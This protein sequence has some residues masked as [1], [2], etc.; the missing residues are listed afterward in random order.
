MIDYFS[1]DTI[2]MIGDPLLESILSTLAL[3]T[4]LRRM[5]RAMIASMG[6]V[7]FMNSA[8]SRMPKSA[9]Q[10]RNQIPILNLVCNFA[11]PN[12]CSTIS[13]LHKFVN[14][15]EYIQSPVCYTGSYS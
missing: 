13:K 8:I 10:F 2:V 5:L 15:V 1:T 9:T 11:I 12:L 14:C 4:S 6:V 7:C 3:H